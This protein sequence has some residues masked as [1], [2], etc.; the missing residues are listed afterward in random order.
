MRAKCNSNRMHSFIKELITMFG[1]Q[2]QLREVY[3]ASKGTPRFKNVN[4]LCNKYGSSTTLDVVLD[5]YEA[6]VK[7][8][9]NKHSIK[10]N[11]IVNTW[12]NRLNNPMTPQHILE[13]NRQCVVYG[14]PVE[15]ALKTMSKVQFKE[16]M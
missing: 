15:E 4:T 10:V 7:S 1:K 13:F 8:Q 14:V 5:I 11:H 2:A 16:V 3:A 6:E 9:A 12:A